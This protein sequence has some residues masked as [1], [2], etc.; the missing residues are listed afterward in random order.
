MR[1]IMDADSLEDCYSHT[2]LFTFTA[3]ILLV[4]SEP[5]LA[6]LETLVSQM[7]HP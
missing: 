2:S 1:K 5:G 6:C 3:G 4:N 7:P